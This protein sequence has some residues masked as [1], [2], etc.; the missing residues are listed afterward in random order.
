[1]PVPI[2]R[3]ASD[4]VIA[5]SILKLLVPQRI[6][7]SRTPGIRSVSL[8]PISVE[9]VSTPIRAA[10]F[11]TEDAPF[12]ICLTTAVVTSC[13]DWLTPSATIPLSAHMITTAF[14]ERSS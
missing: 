2:A 6:L 9:I 3:T 5:G 11:P 10:I 1:M 4:S 14:L 7:R 12:A 8:I 13:P